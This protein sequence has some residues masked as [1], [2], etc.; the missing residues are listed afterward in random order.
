MEFMAINMASS[1]TAH[2]SHSPDRLA[3]GVRGALRRMTV[4][5]VPV[6][7]V[8][9]VFA[10]Q[11]LAPVRW[12]L[13]AARHHR[14]AAAGRRRAARGSSW[15]CTSGCCASRAVPACSRR[16]RA[17]CA[18]LVLGG[19]AVPAG[20]AGI[21][22]AGWRAALHD[23][24]ALVRAPG[25][26]AA[27]RG[28]ARPRRRAP[29]A[30]QGG[31]RFGAPLG[32]S[33]GAY[34]TEEAPGARHRWAPRPRTCRGMGHRD[35][36]RG[37]PV[38]VHGAHDT[39]SWPSAALP[40]PP[41]GPAAATRRPAGRRAHRVGSWRSRPVAAARARGG[42][43]LDPA[44]ARRGHRPRQ[45]Q[46]HRPPPRTCP[47][48]TVVA[49]IL[50]IVMCSAPPSRCTGRAPGCSWPGP[51]DLGGL[52]TAPVSSAYRPTG[53]G[54]L[55][56]ARGPLPHRGRPGRRP[57][58]DR[59]RLPVALQLLCL[60]L[61]AGGPPGLPYGRPA[62]PRAWCGCSRWPAG[63]GSTVRRGRAAVSAAVA[64]LCSWFGGAGR[65]RHAGR[66]AGLSDRERAD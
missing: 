63:R 27:L 31:G 13:R 47:R 32:H 36:A 25:L 34:G 40:V 19:A 60:A 9:V 11:I 41:R 24:M 2:A 46:R 43:L 57:G 10:P 7:L 38:Y 29:V 58:T 51:G 8:L 62:V 21:S 45:A 1:L 20:P 42:P 52:H 61:A 48:S 6:V 59:A 65:T 66:T 17:R 49:G 37:I 3:D 35:P 44:V 50:L 33:R 16:S 26:R 22:G 53:G 54:P 30:L 5:L 39:P 28:A 55:A 64:G 15:S 4:L 14:A 56:R 12:R 23:V 18:L